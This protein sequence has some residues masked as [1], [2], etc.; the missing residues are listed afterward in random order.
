MDVAANLVRLGVGGVRDQCTLLLIEGP[1]A[2]GQRRVCP[3]ARRL[4]GPEVG[5]RLEEVGVRQGA[6]EP[7]REEFGFG[8][9]GDGGVRQWGKRPRDGRSS[10]PPAWANSWSASRT[11]SASRAFSAARSW[12]SMRAICASGTPTS[13]ARWGG[14]RCI[15]TCV[16]NISSY[17]LPATGFQVHP[18]VRGEYSHSLSRTRAGA[19]GVRRRPRGAAPAG[20]VAR[21]AGGCGRP[22]ERR[23]RPADVRLC[24]PTRNGPVPAG[25]RA[26]GPGT[27]QQPDQIDEAHRLSSAPSI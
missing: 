7:A 6:E 25:V 14:Q 3:A 4:H 5:L 9:V 13:A 16:A 8:R 21:A 1:P 26:D 22:L 23:R 18:H 24:R 20:A 27:P 15:P 10:S 2:V 11:P 17:Q 12:R 19:G